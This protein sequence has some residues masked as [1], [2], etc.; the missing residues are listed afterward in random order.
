MD[1]NRIQRLFSA[2]QSRSPRLVLREQWWLV[3]AVLGAATGLVFLFLFLLLRT[4]RDTVVLEVVPDSDAGKIEVWVGGAV[5]Q[6]GLYQLDRGSRVA[7]AIEEAGGI[8]PEAYTE[9]IG[10]AARLEDADQ[11][12]VPSIQAEVSSPSNVPQSNQ[13]ET[14][15]NVNTATQAQLEA[16]PHIGPV[17]ASRIIEYRQQNGPFQSVQEL[18]NISGISDRIVEDLGNQITVS[19]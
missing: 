17:L 19:Q 9:T 18:V 16:L 5:A 12:I 1:R 8:L 7:D 4:P 14:S 3:P 2:S 11:I 6:P 13:Q 10:M 15:V